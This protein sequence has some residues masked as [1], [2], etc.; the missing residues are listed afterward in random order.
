MST[1]TPNQWTLDPAARPDQLSSAVLHSLSRPIAGRIVWGPLKSFILGALTFGILPLIA[2]P[3]KFGRF[4]VAEQQQLWHL[5]EWLRIRTGDEEAARLRDSVRD[6]GAIPTLWIVPIVMLAILALNF[7]P[8]LDVSGLFLQRLFFATYDIGLRHPDTIFSNRWHSGFFPNLRLY[9]IWT[10]CLSVG[11]ASHWL[12]VRQHAADVN[13]LL[14]QLNVIFVRQNLPP[15][16]ISGPGIGLRPLW[17]VAAVVGASCG[18]W[19]AIP[20]ALAGG[21]HQRYI[22]RNSNRI[23]SELAQRVSTLLHQNRPP[24]NVPTPHGFR[25]VCRN[26][27]CAHSMPPGA[28]FCPRCGTRVPPKVGAVA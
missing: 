28:A 15:V 14:G 16:R 27:M 2:W 17:V 12:H 7:F 22:L 23:R 26:E 6:T 24:M 19:W 5:V 4:V 21:V 20:A 9:G 13:R 10:I 11:Y 3:K 18:V 8:W 25:V 1:F